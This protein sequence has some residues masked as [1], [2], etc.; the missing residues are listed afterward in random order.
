VSDEGNTFY[1]AVLEALFAHLE[2]GDQVSHLA[3]QLFTLVERG[4]ETVFI[5]CEKKT[6]VVGGSW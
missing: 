5:G 1:L 3:K 6:A 4:R 2:L